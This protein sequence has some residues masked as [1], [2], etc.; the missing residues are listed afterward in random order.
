[1]ATITAPYYTEQ[2][3]AQ[4]GPFDGEALAAMVEKGSLSGDTLVWRQGMAD[5]ELAS[6]APELAAM[7]NEFAAVRKKKEEAER[8]VAKEAAQKKAAEDQ[9]K[10]EAARKVAAKK[11]MR[12]AFLIII[13]IVAVYAVFYAIVPRLTKRLGAEVSV[14]AGSI[15][16]EALLDRD[17]E[18]IQ[19]A[20]PVNALTKSGAGKIFR[21]SY[22]D[23]YTVIGVMRT[24]GEHRE[25][26]LAEPGNANAFYVEDIKSKEKYPLLALRKFDEGGAGVDL[27]FRRFD[28]RNFN[29]I[30]GADTSNNAWHFMNVKIP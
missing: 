8:K 27:I 2:N 28:S 16:I 3:G 19:S 13:I 11:T 26:T 1:M 12:R 14:P 7:L 4:A 15:P 23:D 22:G 21:V 9:A 29:L 10:A 6:T 24:T 17:G 20:L 30:E 5:W 25:I 18:T